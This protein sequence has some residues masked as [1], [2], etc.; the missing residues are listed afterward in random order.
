MKYLNGIRR[1]ERFH[2]ASVLM[3]KSEKSQIH[4]LIYVM[5]D[6]MLSSFKLSEANT[7]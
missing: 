4:T 3:T 7:K 5:G 6:D 2:C 1:F